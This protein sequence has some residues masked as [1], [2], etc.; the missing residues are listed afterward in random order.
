MARG[1]RKPQH[2]VRKYDS[3]S[4]RYGVQYFDWADWKKQHRA[5]GEGF[6]IFEKIQKALRPFGNIGKPL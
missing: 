3:F 4:K 5:R 1:S 6:R 2:N